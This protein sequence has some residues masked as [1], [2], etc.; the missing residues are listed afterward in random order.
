MRI[1]KAIETL[2]GLLEL[3]GI[4][5]TWLEGELTTQAVD[6]AINALEL[7]KRIDDGLLVPKEFHDKTYALLQQRYFDLLEKTK[8]IPVSERLPDVEREVLLY[9]NTMTWVGFL[10]DQKRWEVVGD[11][12]TFDFNLTSHWMLLPEPPDV[13]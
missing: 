6:M 13:W 7:Q 11:D 1:E 12:S 5:H 9:S 4:G 3:N 10:N 2:K 8:W